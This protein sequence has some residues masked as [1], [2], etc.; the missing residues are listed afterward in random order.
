MK[1]D[2]TGEYY[3]LKDAFAAMYMHQRAEFD[4]YV[5]RHDLLKFKEVREGIDTANGKQ[6]WYEEKQKD[7]NRVIKKRRTP[8]EVAADKAREEQEG[9]KKKK[10]ENEKRIPKEK[11]R[12][13]N[14]EW[15][16]WPPGWKYESL[17]PGSGKQ[18]MFQGPI[19][20]SYYTELAA[21]LKR[22][23]YQNPKLDR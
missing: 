1:T 20:R 22:Y 5:K 10:K 18:K 2:F 23:N 21:T 19:D 8:A 4:A 3:V 15:V 9:G 12:R 7:P 13:F 6:Q 17:V 16:T 11:S 14:F